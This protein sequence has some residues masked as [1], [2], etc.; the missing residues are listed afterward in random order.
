MTRQCGKGILGAEL[1]VG[2]N[3]KEFGKKKKTDAYTQ[4]KTPVYGAGIVRAGFIVADRVELY[5]LGGVRFNKLAPIVGA[6]ARFYSKTKSYFFKT[7]FQKTLGN[8]YPKGHVIKLG[9]GWT[10]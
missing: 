8:K 1:L 2:V 5:A 6:G 9:F 4:N 3:C 10:I 7:E